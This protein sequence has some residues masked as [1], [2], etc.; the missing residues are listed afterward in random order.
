MV[1]RLDNY[2][3]SRKPEFYRHPIQFPMVPMHAID[4]NL[5]IEGFPA[6]FAEF[7]KLGS[8]YCLKQ[9]VRERWKS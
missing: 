1:V 2:H 7:N 4:T 9:C 8:T 5:A 6:D 3:I